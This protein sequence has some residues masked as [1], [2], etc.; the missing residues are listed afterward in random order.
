MA[1]AGRVNQAI[2][3][4]ILAGPYFTHDIPKTTGRETFGDNWS[5]ELCERMIA[6]GATPEDCLA[7]ITRVTAKALADDY[8]RWGPME[9]V[10]EIYLGGGGSFNPAIIDY[11][12][13]RFPKTKIAYLD[14]LGIP[15]G[16]REASDFSFKGL[17]LAV[18]RALMP[19]V[20]TESD[21]AG[22]T[23]HMQPGSGLNYHR[24]M[25]HVHE[26]WGNYP[27]EKRMN[28]VT[29]MIVVPYKGKSFRL[30]MDD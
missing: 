13:E 21:R 17:E 5:Q 24:M 25:Q 23:G 18:G 26:F 19:P 11:L 1:K 28:P 3:D 10:D 27:L 12:R 4:E 9:G 15:C 16:A 29:K 7:T 22:I 8:E 6:E 14:E 2:V 30:G 20:K